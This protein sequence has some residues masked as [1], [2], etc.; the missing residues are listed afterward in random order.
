MEPLTVVQL[1]LLVTHFFGLAAIIGP[2]FFQLRKKTGFDF[3]VMLI[4]AITQLVTGL[5]LVG[6]LQA[7]DDATVNNAKIAVKLVLALIVLVAV[8]I[9]RGR[10][11][12]AL[13]AG[14]TDRVSLPWLHIT[15]AGA[16]VNVIVAVFWV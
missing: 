13:A 14:G 16:V 11:K 10:Q 3:R 15:G 9:A 2:F 5:A 12:K 1:V 8:L 7:S 4:G 6:V